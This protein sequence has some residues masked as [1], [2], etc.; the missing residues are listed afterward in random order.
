MRLM[1]LMDLRT[2]GRGTNNAM[3]NMAKP[4]KKTVFRVKCSRSKLSRTII[5]SILRIHRKY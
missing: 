4:E 5:V 2:N 1:P 3:I